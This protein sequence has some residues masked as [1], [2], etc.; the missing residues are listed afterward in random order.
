MLK[1]FILPLAAVVCMAASQTQAASVQV[2]LHNIVPRQGHVLVSICTVAEFADFKCAHRQ[3]AAAPAA[4]GDLV[5]T[6]PN[7]APGRYAVS[8]YQDLN[9]NHRLDF[10]FNGAP[11]EPW[12]FSGAGG[13]MM[14]PPSFDRTAIDIREPGLS[15]DIALVR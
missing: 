12:G 13:R 15:L 5:F 3:M 8:T 6:F 2:R 4:G 11:S 10:G 9:D 14:G 1:P 7:V